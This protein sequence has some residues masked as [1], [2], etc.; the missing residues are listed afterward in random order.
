MARGLE[1]KFYEEWLKELGRFSLNK[2]RIRG[3]VIAVFQHM[4][5]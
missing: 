1:V 3:N 4:K 5:G 2:R